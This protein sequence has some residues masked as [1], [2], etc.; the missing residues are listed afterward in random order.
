MMMLEGSNHKVV[1]VRAPQAVRGDTGES[2]PPSSVSAAALDPTELVSRPPLA[3]DDQKNAAVKS[4]RQKR[5]GGKRGSVDKR[6]NKKNTSGGKDSY[7]RIIDSAS[8][9][10]HSVDGNGFR[11]SY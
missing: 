10:G 6:H 7:L 3:A 9:D 4:S 5:G 1:V 2:T 11:K 8:K